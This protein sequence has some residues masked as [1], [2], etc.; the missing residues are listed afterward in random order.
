MNYNEFGSFIPRQMPDLL[1]ESKSAPVD[2][3]QQ[4]GE[5]VMWAPTVFGA[6]AKSPE[7]VMAGI[8]TRQDA[9]AKRVADVAHERLRTMLT[10]RVAGEYWGRD[11]CPACGAVVRPSAQPRHLAWHLRIG[12]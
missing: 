4:S 2:A 8:G 9:E 3:D 6:A 10:D 11:E 7:A 12:R 5:A 1:R